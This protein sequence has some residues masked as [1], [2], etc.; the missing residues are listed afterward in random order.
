KNGS[1]LNDYYGHDSLLH[2]FFYILGTIYTVIY[3]MHVTFPSYNGPE[4]IVGSSTGG[5]V[6]ADIVLGVSWIIIVGAFFMTFLLNYG[7]IDFVGSLM[8]PLM[9]PLFK[10]PGKSAIDAI[11][12]FVSSSSIAVIITSRLFKMNVYTKREAAF[13]ATSFSAVSVGFALLVINTAG[14]GDHFI[15]TYFSSL[16]ITFLVAI[17]MCRIPPLSRKPSEYF[18]G[19]IQTEEDRKGEA[20]FEM[21]VFKR[22]LDRAAKRGYTARPLAKEIIIS[23][24][25]GFGVIPKVVTLVAAAGITGLIIA[26]YTPFFHWIGQVFVPLLQ[27]LGVPDAQAIAPSI[28]VGFAEMFLPVLLI[29]DNVEFIDIGARYFITALSMVQVIFLAEAV[30]VMLAT[31]LPV[32]FLELALLFLV[33]TLVAIPIVAIF[34]HL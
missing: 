28:P 16:V 10:V 3:T 7:G 23:L 11:A 26:E 1:K 13:I 8:E 19:K 22:G 5:T 18:S 33:R 32:K 31:R 12:S 24:K 15:K 29:A 30:V 6:V 17:V 27:V 34:M 21:A 2:P 4:M 9:R 20:K 14:L 25:E